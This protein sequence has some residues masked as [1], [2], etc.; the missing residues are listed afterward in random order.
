LQ[1]IYWILTATCLL[2]AV[3]IARVPC[4][5]STWLAAFLFYLAS[6]SGLILLDAQDF[7]ISPQLYFVLLTTI[8][9]PGP[10][11]LGYV[12]HISD[13]IKISFRDFLPATLPISVALFSPQLLSNNEMFSFA[14]VSDYEGKSYTALF[15]LVSILAGLCMLTYIV[16]CIRVLLQARTD[17]S[18]Y[19]SKTLPNNWYRMLQVILVLLA[20]SALQVISSFINV[21]GDKASIGD[22]SFIF[23]IVYFIHIAIQTIK[24]NS[25]QH[26]DE[27]LITSDITESIQSN[28]IEN[29]NEELIQLSESSKQRIEHYQLYLQ[30]DLSLASL[31][32]Q[33]ET[34]PNKLSLAINNI[35]NQSFYEFINDYRIKYAAE[36]LLEEPNKSITEVYFAAGFTSKSTFYSYFKNAYHCTP[37]QFRKKDTSN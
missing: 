7:Y 28:V 22:I 32:E 37:S 20:V 19:Q 5:S 11:L 30:E 26:I 21:S 9:L 1:L 36:M 23:L 34:T 25:T 29:N 4:K 2:M 8:F 35:F 10:I 14:S 13:R 31:A 33:L 12:G 3:S 24:E 15:N 17:W 16:L 27:E 18:S 6:Y